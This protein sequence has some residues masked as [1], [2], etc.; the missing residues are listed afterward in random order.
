M[1]LTAK[2]Q[3][4]L[5]ELRKIG[6]DNLYRY[7]GVT[8]CLHSNDCARV[9]AGDQACPFGLGGLTYQIGHRLDIGAGSVLS[10]L[11]ALQRKGLV[12]RDESYPHYQRARYWWPVGLAAELAAEL[13]AED[14]VT[15]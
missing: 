6:R 12:I 15:P 7:R 3:I 11:N 5:D 10:T 13:K 8:P 9:T 1:K 2:Q 4:V 14:V